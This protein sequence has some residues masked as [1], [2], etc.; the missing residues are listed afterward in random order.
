MMCLC[1]A[2]SA[3]DAPPPAP[4]ERLADPAIEKSFQ[5]VLGSDRPLV[6]PDAWQRRYGRAETVHVRGQATDAE[7]TRLLQ[8]A[9]PARVRRLGPPGKARWAIQVIVNGSHAK[10]G[11]GYSCGRLCGAG[12]SLVFERTPQGWVWLYATD[13]WIS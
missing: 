6:L 4:Q 9:Q 3:A 11:Y 2:A 1:M 10:I 5:A 12:E 13:G 8:D 7:V